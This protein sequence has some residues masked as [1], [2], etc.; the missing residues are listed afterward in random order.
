VDKKAV[1]DQQTDYK[2]KK[3]EE[4]ETSRR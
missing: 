2:N 1:V 3:D 4:T